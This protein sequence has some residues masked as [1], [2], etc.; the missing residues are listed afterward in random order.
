MYKI[1]RCA[2]VVQRLKCSRSTIYSSVAEGTFPAPI[3]LGKRAVA[4]PEG[5]VDAMVAAR[6]AGAS[7]EQIKALVKGLTQRRGQA[8]NATIAALRGEAGALLP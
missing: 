2:E 5:E 1:L 6:V 4:W 3:R 8:L 7:A